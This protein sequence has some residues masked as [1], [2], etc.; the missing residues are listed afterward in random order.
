MNIK[1]W[2]EKLN[3]REYCKEL[4]DDEERQLKADGIIA[5]FGASDDLLEFRGALNDEAGAWD[6]TTVR[7]AVTGDGEIKVFNEDENRETAEFNKMQIANMKTVSAIWCP[8]DKNNE[9]WASW[10]IQISDIPY[11]NFDILED[12]E[13]YCRGIVFEANCLE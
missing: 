12:G 2:A 3:E 11:A 7:L 4:T 1:E 6:G 5:A 13:L 9:V 10:L 8:V